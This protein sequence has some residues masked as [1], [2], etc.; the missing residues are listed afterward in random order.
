MAETTLP[1]LRVSRE[2]A[3]QKIEAQIEKGQRLRTWRINS[4]N[5]LHKADMA[6][7]NWSKY[8]EILLSQ[9]FV[10][11]SLAENEYVCYVDFRLPIIMGKPESFVIKERINRHQKNIAS[12]I[13][14]LEGIRER[15]ELYDNPSNTLQSTFGDK[16]FIVHG[17]DNEAKVTVARFVEHLGIE[18]T[19]LDEEVNEGQTIPEKFEEHA[20]DAGFAIILLTPDDVGASEDERDDLKPRARQNVIFELGYFIGKLGRKRVCL[21]LKGE[22]ENPSDLDGILYVSM[23]SPNGWKLEL[24]REMNRAKLPIDPEKLL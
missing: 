17:H 18:A 23:N 4:D 8:N 24:A 6:A 21:L 7:K 12:S 22:L 9:L 16:V 10:D 19:I 2:E 11:T 1:K 20:D 14:S 3:R 5:E 13:S 15:L